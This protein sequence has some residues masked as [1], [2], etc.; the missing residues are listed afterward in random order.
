MVQPNPCDVIIQKKSDNPSIFY[1]LGTLASPGQFSFHDRDEAIR[2]AVGY[3]RHA[4]VRAWLLNGDEH[5][6]L[7]RSDKTENWNEGGHHGA[8]RRCAL[9]SAT[10]NRRPDAHP[11]ARQRGACRR[12]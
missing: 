5:V 4:H 10:S 11:Q 8:E 2:H 6:V 12:E 9:C 7:G 3:A 1:V